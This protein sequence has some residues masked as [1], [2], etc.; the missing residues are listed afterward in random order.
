MGVPRSSGVGSG[1]VAT[2]DNVAGVPSGGVRATPRGPGVIRTAGPRGPGPRKGVRAFPYADPEPAGD[3]DDA[4]STGL[5]NTVRA[6]AMA[7]S[8][9]TFRAAKPDQGC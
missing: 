5:R 1:G 8:D 7:V 9:E 3:L 4:V 2:D 6:A